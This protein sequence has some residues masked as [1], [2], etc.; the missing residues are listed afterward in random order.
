MKPPHKKRIQVVVMILEE[1]I[2]NLDKIDRLSAVKILKDTYTK[3]NIQPIRGKALSADI[4]DKEMTT[5][6]VIGKHGLKLDLDYPEL[7]KKVFYIEE[8]LEEI[9][10]DI[11]DGKDDVAR[12]KLKKLSPSGTIESNIIARLLR[13][14]L[15]KLILG[16]I[17][18]DDFKNILH[19]VKTVFHEE[20]KTV[21]NYARFFTG[22]V[23]SE[24]IYK[25]SVKT[26]EEKEALKK[27]LA[28]R[29]GFPKAVPSDEYIRVIAKNVY[30]VSDKLLDK[31][32]SSEN[33]KTKE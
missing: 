27:A 6:Y 10:T 31:I 17:S 22:I 9:I 33:S 4:F 5:I 3:E 32:L 2:R 7:F 28:I 8:A 25:G 18:E 29:I 16:F 19:R 23:L 30:G 20:E 12:E 21:G 13:I 1:Y 26:R 14:P 24:L 11:I 15:T